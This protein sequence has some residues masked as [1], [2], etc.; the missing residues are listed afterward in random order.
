MV[1]F[2]KNVDNGHPFAHLVELD[3]A[4]ALLCFFVDWYKLELPIYTRVATLAMGQKWSDLWPLLLRKLI[5]DELNAHWFSMDN[6]LSKRG[7][8]KIRV[9]KSQIVKS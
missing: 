4:C 8:R 7:H 6:L 5:R 3:K 2:L 1:R 9:N